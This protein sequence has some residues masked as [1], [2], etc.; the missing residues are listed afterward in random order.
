L[1]IH[2]G[3]NV[4]VVKEM[5]GHQSLQ[6]T[7]KYVHMIGGSVEEVSDTYFLGLEVP[8]KTVLKLA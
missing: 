3:V 4:K 5:A 1:W 7:M 8:P 6:T 2:H